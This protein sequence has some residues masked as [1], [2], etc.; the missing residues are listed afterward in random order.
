MC[1][2]AAAFLV[3]AEIVLVCLNVAP[4][5]NA[6][7]SEI[8]TEILVAAEVWCAR[9]DDAFGTMKGTCS[10]TSVTVAILDCC[11]LIQYN[12]SPLRGWQRSVRHDLFLIVVETPIPCSRVFK[13][14]LSPEVLH[15]KV[16]VR[17]VFCGYGLVGGKD[18]VVFA[19]TRGSEVVVGDMFIGT[20]V[21]SC[22][23]D[24]I[25]V[26]ELLDLGLP[27]LQQH[28]GNYDECWSDNIF[29]SFLH[30]NQCQ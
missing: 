25:D 29:I 13:R 14:V 9:K 3:I 17:L 24:G 27:L 19:K 12:S 8:A 7:E 16:Q 6:Q 2:V 15:L 10:F 28:L 30:C 5:T 18:D 22:E 4:R 11:S 23:G 20:F 21:V 1:F 26:Q